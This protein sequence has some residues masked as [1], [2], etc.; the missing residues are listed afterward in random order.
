MATRAKA[1]VNGGHLCISSLVTTNVLPQTVMVS[2]NN[3]T[4]PKR[5]GAAG[6]GAFSHVA[7]LP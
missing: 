3:K 5:E 2:S 4:E 1:S 6:I 7:T